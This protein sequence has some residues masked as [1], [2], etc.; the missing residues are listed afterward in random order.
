[1]PDSNT[2]NYGFV[3][4][5]VGASQ[6]SWGTKLNANWDD[7]DTELKNLADTKANLASPALTGTPTA[8]TAAQGTNT[9]QLATTEYVQT[10]VGAIDLSSVWPVGSVYIN[11]AVATNPSTLLGFGTW[12]EIGAGKVLVGQDTLDTDFD[13]LGE[14]GGSK[15]AVVVSHTHTASTDAAGSH[16]HT[17]TKYN[18]DTSSGYGL[19]AGSPYDPGSALTGSAGSHSHTVTVDS[20]GESGTG[21]NVQPYIVVKMWQRTA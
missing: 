15:D 19:A 20:A 14:T 5:E 7:A 2:T 16:Q 10:E 9:T 1:M 21:K 11:A 13:V 18:G 4:P 3:K 17:Y 6:D 12:V 8:P